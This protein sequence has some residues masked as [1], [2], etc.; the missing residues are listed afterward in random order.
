[1]RV[2]SWAAVA[3]LTWGCA[4]PGFAQEAATSTSLEAATLE[5][6]Y[7]TSPARKAEA[8]AMYREARHNVLG[9]FQSETAG[10]SRHRMLEAAYLGFPYAVVQQC[11]SGTDDSGRDPSGDL[12][13]GLAWCR[14][15]VALA[16][17]QYGRFAEKQVRQLS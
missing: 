15:S 10:A 5:T 7:Q 11:M 1:M 9:G 8:E 12:P 17:G 2:R 14:V 16:P 3:C 6:A 13:L 4:V